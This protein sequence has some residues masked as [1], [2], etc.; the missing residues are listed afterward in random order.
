MDCYRH[1]ESFLYQKDEHDGWVVTLY[2]DFAEMLRIDPAKARSK[3]ERYEAPTETI[4]E[5]VQKL[6]TKGYSLVYSLD[7][8]L[9]DLI[10][11]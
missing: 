11:V 8:K 5:A 7:L 1:D 2:G 9:R 10:H 6:R 3:Y 4:K